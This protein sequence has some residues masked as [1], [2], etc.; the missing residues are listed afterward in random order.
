MHRRQRP[1]ER[2]TMI[3]G[4]RSGIPVI[5]AVDS[6]ARGPALGGC[7]IMAYETWDDGLDDAVRLASAMTGKAALAGL[8]HGGGKTV[9]ALAPGR[10]LSPRTRTDLLLDI[11]DLVAAQHGTYRTG[12]DVGTTPDD[13]AEI[14]TRT[15][16]VLCRPP[17]LGGSGDSSG[18]TA[19]GT[20]AALDLLRRRVLDD[21]PWDTVTITLIGAGRVGGH[22]AGALAGHGARVTLSDIDPATQDLA[23][24][25]GASWLPPG[26]A[27]AAR[28]DILVPAAGGGLL[29]PDTITRLDCTI[30]A[31]PAN[32]QLDHPDTA[33]LLHRAGI[34]WAPDPLVSAGGIIHATATELEHLP[35]E[36]ALDRVREI[37]ARLDD[38]LTTAEERGISPAR[39]AEERIEQRLPPR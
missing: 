26:R 34:V 32:N 23:H 35:P 9:A 6:T 25:I 7:R 1:P 36:Q 27:L 30:I 10:T 14:A 22:L 17:H 24:R 3:V 2:L 20:L 21:R 15:P 12:P 16:Y 8:D 33:E 28:S 31:G 37:G 4:G 39:A 19:V 13:M 38:L 18:P 11:G 5:L 29:T